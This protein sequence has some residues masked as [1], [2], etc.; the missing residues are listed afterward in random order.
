MSELNVRLNL[1]KAAAL[2]LSLFDITGKMVADLGRKNLT[3]GSHLLQYDMSQ[4]GLKPGMYHLVI[5]DDSGGR[6]V[7]KMMRIQE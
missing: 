5:S 7:K 2:S 6:I 1:K 3:T 4:F